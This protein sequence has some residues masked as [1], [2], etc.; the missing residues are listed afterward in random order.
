MYGDFELGKSIGNTNGTYEARDRHS[1]Q[2]VAAFK[3]R[4]GISPNG[5]RWYQQ[6][7]NSIL[8][9]EC[10]AWQVARLLG[11]PFSEIVAPCVLR[12]ID[13]RNGA[14][15]EWR[16]GTA[17]DPRCYAVRPDQ[18]RT[19]GLFDCVIGQQDR[20]VTNY[21]WNPTRDELALIDHGYAFAR[22]NDPHNRVSAFHGWRWDQ[23]A[24]G[25]VLDQDEHDALNAF[26]SGSVGLGIIEQC[27]EPARGKAL[28]QR[29]DHLVSTRQLPPPHTFAP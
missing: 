20:N 8:I 26:A 4:D 17:P 21:L 22:D 9:A 11:T 6:T 28:R 1:G 5:M 3:P 2:V 14:L 13:G 29:V 7:R 16:E 10:V 23:G 24:A 25:R 15:A 19:A 27:L 12:K 18:C